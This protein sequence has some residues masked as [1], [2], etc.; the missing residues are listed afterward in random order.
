MLHHLT[1]RSTCRGAGERASKPR[2]GGVSG[3][4]WTKCV[5][6]T[7]STVLANHRTQTFSASF[8]IWGEQRSTTLC[9]GLTKNN[10][11]VCLPSAI[12]T[13]LRECSLFL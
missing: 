3:T 4:H 8:V 9:A 11:P 13:S 5:R 6:S 10:D 7:A 12:V 1:H 2:E